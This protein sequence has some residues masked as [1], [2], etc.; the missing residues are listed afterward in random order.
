MIRRLSEF[1]SLLDNNKP[2]NRQEDLFGFSERPV[3]MPS[4]S[5]F[6]YEHTDIDLITAF[7]SGDLK[8][9]TLPEPACTL[10][11]LS[12]NAFE[13]LIHALMSELAIEKETAA[14]GRKVIAASHTARNPEE[15]RI[16]AERALYDRGDAETLTALNVSAKVQREIHRMT[17]LLR[18]LPD[19][20]GVF[21][22][23]CSPDHL[24]LPALGVYFTARF[25]ETAWAVI[26]EKRSLCLSGRCAEQA[27]ITVQQDLTEN[28][29]INQDSDE[30]EA[31]WKHY[32][33]TINNESRDNPNLQRQLMPRRYW[34]YL[35][36]KT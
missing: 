35:P 25:G 9:S 23:K 33:K 1:F 27:T 4:S 20:N 17:E 34:K 24:V 12:V 30:W 18:F 7:Y 22:A 2:I 6:Q 21:I 5:P 32:H 11:E 16:A 10:L 29:I 3:S 15:K 19:T 26:D 14:F 13:I 28:Y 36:E 31:L 8:P